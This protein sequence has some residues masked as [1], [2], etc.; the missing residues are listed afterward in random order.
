[1]PNVEALLVA[2]GPTL[3]LQPKPPPANVSVS[4][5]GLGGVTQAK[6]VQI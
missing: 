6:F 5:G 2:P 3:Q 1:M 4:A